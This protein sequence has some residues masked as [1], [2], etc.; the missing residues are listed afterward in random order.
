MLHN[1]I[2]GNRPT[3]SVK[4]IFEGFSPYI[5]GHGGHLGHATSIISIN[6]H[7][8]VYKSLHTKFGFKWPSDF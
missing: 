4:K 7:F 3:D 1:K 2:H 5:Y 6:F 8:H